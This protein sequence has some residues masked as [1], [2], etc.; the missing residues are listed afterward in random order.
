MNGENTNGISSLRIRFSLIVV[1]L[2]LLIFTIGTKPVW[3]GWDRS[4]IVGFTQIVV[5]LIGLALIC[6]GGFIG[7]SSLWGREQRSI[8]ADIGLRLV[9]TGYVIAVFTGL[10]DVFGMGSQPLPKVPYFGPWQAGGVMIGEI[11]I[12]I[13]F[14]M[15]IP[16]RFYFSR[17]HR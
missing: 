7:L 12:A 9:G 17:I 3:F 13:G 10:A 5:F 14:L 1:P 8:I 15:V 11:V 4:P 2:G 16:Y 6:L